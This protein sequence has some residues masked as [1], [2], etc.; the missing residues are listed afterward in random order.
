MMAMARYGVGG[1]RFR[2]WGAPGQRRGPQ[3]GGSWAEGSRTCAVD[4]E[5]LVGQGKWQMVRTASGLA[6]A[7]RWL[8]AHPARWRSPCSPGAGAMVLGA[9]RPSAYRSSA[10]VE[11]RAEASG[12]KRRKQPLLLDEGLQWI[13]AMEIGARG[14]GAAW[15]ARG[16]REWQMAWGAAAAGVVGTDGDAVGTMPRHARAGEN[17]RWAGCLCGIGP[18]L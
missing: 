13:R 16:G 14:G 7:L 3:G 18:V 4:D 9:R 1:S 10:H 17:G 2:V 8:E 12:E 5:V 6:V 15:P 11:E